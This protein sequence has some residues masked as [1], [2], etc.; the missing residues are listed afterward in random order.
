MRKFA[1]LTPAV[2]QSMLFAADRLSLSMCV[3]V[4]FSA[5]TFGFTCI[6]HPTR[7]QPTRS[8]LPAHGAPQP[9]A[10]AEHPHTVFS[11][12]RAAHLGSDH[13]GSSDADQARSVDTPGCLDL[14]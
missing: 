14:D 11:L 13:A 10:P 6:C 2:S 3:C 9:G 12:R 5:G 4:C 8:H 7:V 1:A